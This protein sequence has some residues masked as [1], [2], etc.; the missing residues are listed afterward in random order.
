MEVAMY[1]VS[2]YGS[3]ET[4]G[5]AAKKPIVPIALKEKE[6]TNSPILEQPKSDV[7][8]FKGK[9][10]AEGNSSTGKKVFGALAVAALLIGGLGCA[11]KYN[12]V[13]KLKDG[14]FKDFMQKS[15]KITEPCHKLCAKTKD[16]ACKC[17]DKIKN[18]FNKK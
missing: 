10:Y 11:H 17:Y 3:G 12:L 2:F 9:D 6:T 16:Y 5:S 8:C 13:G 4:A 7:V 15:D 1:N 18:I 14:K